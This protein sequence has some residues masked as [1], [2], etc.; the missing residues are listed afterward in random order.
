[1]LVQMDLCLGKVEGGP[2]PP[3]VSETGNPIPG[4]ALTFICRITILSHSKTQAKP[5]FSCVHREKSQAGGG[6]AYSCLGSKTNVPS[7]AN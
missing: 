5:Y 2:F 1:M 7:K 3:G 4:T 6:P